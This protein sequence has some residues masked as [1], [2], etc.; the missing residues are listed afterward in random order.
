MVGDHLCSLPFSWA[1]KMQTQTALSTIE[2]E[3]IVMFTALLEQ[4]PI[5]E[6]LKEVVVQGINVQ[7]K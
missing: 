4:I 2:A 3:Y 5:L 7:C 1:S 6:L